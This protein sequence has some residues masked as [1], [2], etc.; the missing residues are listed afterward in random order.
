M[1][2]SVTEEGAEDAVRKLEGML[3]RDQVEALESRE[4]RLF[5]DGG[6]VKAALASEREKLQKESWR[7]LLPGYVRRFIEKSA[8][9]LNL[10]TDGDLDSTF[11][12]KPVSPR[13]LDFLWTLLESYQPARRNRL[14]VVKPKD[15][16]DV[17]F[18]HPGG[19]V[20][21]R[22]RTMVCGRFADQAFRGGIFVDPQIAMTVATA[23]EEAAG[24]VVRDV[25]KPNLARAAGLTDSPGFDLLSEH[26]V[27]GQKGI[28]VKG[29]AGIGDVELT[30][31]EWAKACNEPKRYWLYVV[32]D[33]V[34]PHPRL[35]KVNG[36]FGKLIVGSKSIVLVKAQDVLMASESDRH[37]R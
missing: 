13:A 25:S 11:A 18:L 16:T 31:N 35:V 7:R 10:E 37:V 36:P 8:P 9:I 27:H 3:T 6:D 33:F 24:A 2:Q 15:A 30:E 14:T 21:E 34:T 29:R 20:F 4:R 26:L 22:L 32:V 19:P 5:G 23:H 28:E 17:I 12:L 1:E